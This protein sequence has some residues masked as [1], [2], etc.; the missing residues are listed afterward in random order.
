MKI[1][2][3]TSR[4]ENVKPEGPVLKV[5]TRGSALAL[6]QSGMIVAELARHGFLA[7]LVV[8]STAGDRIQDRALSEIGG[9]GLFVKE[10]EDALLR[11]EIDLA[12]HS[13]KDVP[14][15]MHSELHVG[16]IPK[17]ADPRD[18]LVPSDP[19]VRRVEDLPEGALIATGSLRRKLHLSA[20]RPDLRFTELRGNVDTRLRKVRAGEGGMGGTILAA[21]GLA[22][23]GVSVPEGIA[24]SP[25]QMLPAIGQGAL[26][27]QARADAFEL[28]ALLLTIHDAD[29]ATCVSAER[30]LL[31]RLGGDCRTPIA[32]FG[33][34]DGSE[35]WLRGWV[36]SVDGQRRF[37][38]ELRSPT[39][40]A[41]RSGG[42]LA[43]A[44]VRDGAGAV[45]R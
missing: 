19:S 40:Y 44:L 36:A 20:L 3:S 8:I 28:E 32:G 39:A 2:G 43:E 5:G 41:R 27:I 12:I 14:A 18:V 34:V 7:E 29:T 31:E 30:E 33:M 25:E 4:V 45:L 13:M 16:A 6:A 17:R 21:A 15:V 26:C 10:I 37:S 22:R 9:K 1:V 35:I 24:L 23:L 11:G 42:A 38:A